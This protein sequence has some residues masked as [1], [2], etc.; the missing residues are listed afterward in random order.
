MKITSEELINKLKLVC[1]L[2]SKVIDENTSFNSIPLDSMDI[3]SFMLE[4]EESYEIKITN[5]EISKLET[6]NQVLEFILRQLKNK[7]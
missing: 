7:A 6:I 3:A 1:D 2:E 4:L 5:N